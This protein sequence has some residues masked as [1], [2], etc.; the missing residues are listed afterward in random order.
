MRKV[1]LSWIILVGLLSGCQAAIQTPPVEHKT[2]LPGKYDPLRLTPQATVTAG[3]FPLV[4]FPAPILAAQVDLAQKL[5]LPVD[6]VLI[7]Q[8]EGSS[9]PDGCLGLGQVDESCSQEVVPGYRVALQANGVL[10]EYHTDETGSL[11]RLVNEID[12]AAQVPVAR[13]RQSLAAQ[14]GV[15]AQEI[16]TYDAQAETWPDSCLGTEI[17]DQV[18]AQ[19]LNPGFRILLQQSGSTYEL[20]T[21]VDGSQVVLA[22]KLAAPMGTLYMRLRR[23]TDTADC[24]QVL[25]SSSGVAQGACSSVLTAALFSD[26][27][28]PQEL[29]DLVAQFASFEAQTPSGWFEFTGRGTM[30]TVAEQQRALAAWVELTAQELF[31]TR[32]S[33]SDTGLT[34]RRTG[35]IAGACDELQ[36]DASGWAVRLT[37]NGEVV[38]RRFLDAG[39]LIQFFQVLDQYAPG[40][41]TYKEP[42][43]DGFQYAVELR[44]H[45]T[46]ALDESAQQQLLTLAGQVFAAQTP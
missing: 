24:F 33:E 21:N 28:R 5:N 13:A 30:A 34:W 29:S 42:V 35:G 1:V 8:Y 31:G 22:G 17:P 20:H 15:D 46:T 2:P 14:L 26:A 45:G 11:V 4:N 25:V 18:C 38:W 40:Q 39:S 7:V 12:P 16:L 3:Q 43:A 6:N 44:S 41:V 19:Q 10:Y 32:G 9:W 36:M 27:A 37:C 23:N